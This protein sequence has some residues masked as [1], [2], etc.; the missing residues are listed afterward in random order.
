MRFLYTCL[1]LL[2]IPVILLRLL[3]RSIKS[4]RYRRRWRE[5]FGMVRAEPQSQGG[6]WVHAVS[7]GETIAAVP[8]IKAIQTRWPNLPVW[9]T[10]MT[11][12]G[13]AQ[14]TK[15]FGDSVHHV[16]A[17]YDL[18]WFINGFLKAV[19][20]KLAVVMETE[21]WPNTISGCYQQQIPVLLANAR[22]SEKS[23]QGYDRIGRLSRPMLQKLTLIAAQT[24][25]DAERFTRLGVEDSQLIVTG[26]IKFDLDISEQLKA[27][28]ASLK[29]QL[30]G[31]ENR[32]VF[33]A[34]STH[35]GEDEQILEAFAKLKTA[36]SNLLLILVP[37][38]P[39]RFDQVAGLCEKSGLGI[40]R[41]SEGALPTSTDAVYLGDTV[42]DL[43]LLFG[44]ADVAFVGG[45]LV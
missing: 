17:P 21:L 2:L 32:E 39:E 4:P 20:P 3:W 10:T 33:I 34:A 38:H 5:R 7:V 8:M 22:L 11:P 12:T 18:P 44:A 42:G 30:R 28:A 23:W 37:R 16:Y 27:Q 36:I 41:R 14:V 43:L 26:N 6:I 9:V 13:S 25:A 45:S 19:K 15:N 1:Y 24:E 35:Q 40:A 31:E 29:A